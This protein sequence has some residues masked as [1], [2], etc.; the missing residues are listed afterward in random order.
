MRAPRDFSGMVKPSSCRRG[1]CDVF[2]RASGYAPP[3]PAR[4]IDGHLLALVQAESM[5]CR[6]F[7]L[8]ADAGDDPK[9]QA[10]DDRSAVRPSAG[11]EHSL[12]LECRAVKPSEACRT[13]VRDQDFTVVGDRAG[14]AWKS[15]QR[16]FVLARIV[17]DHFD[18]VARSMRDEDP[19]GSWI[20]R[21]VIEG[22]VRSVRNLDD[23]E[24]LQRHGDLASLR[25][26][27]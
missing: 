16:R 2:C 4:Q 3:R 7:P 11:L 21:G 24:V 12:G 23:A 1:H 25:R 14:Y 27:K 22:A 9:C 19:S 6:S 10:L 13:A 15:R 5:Q 17:I 18:D 26:W 20:E 8:V